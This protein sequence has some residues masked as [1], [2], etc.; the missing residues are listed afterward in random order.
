MK[1]CGLQKTTLIDYPGK[2]ACTIFLYG[3]NFRCGF[4][5]N[6]ELVIKENNNIISENEVLDFL[7]KRK[8]Y[9]EG[10]CITGGEP[11]ISLNKDFLRKIKQKGYLIKL[12]TNGSFPE[13]LKDFINNNLIDFISM[14]IKSSKENYSLITNA[15]ININDI[16]ESIKLIL[17]SNLDYELR[18]TIV[19]D[20]HDKSELRKMSLWLNEITGKKPKKFVLQGFNNNGKFINNKYELKA[21]ISEIYLNELKN[22]ITDFFEIIEIRV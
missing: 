5:H 18:T 16:E 10:V 8:K 14:D 9:L 6:P 22:E 19:D 11:L 4:C 13:K 2:I 3:C 15:K 20:F 21:D 12:D 17:N 7:E 1:I